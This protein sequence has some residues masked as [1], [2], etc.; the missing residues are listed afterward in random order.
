MN[1]NWCNDLI[2]TWDVLEPDQ[3]QGTSSRVQTS[4]RCL[5]P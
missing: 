3:Q 5:T 4:C 2:G 1:G